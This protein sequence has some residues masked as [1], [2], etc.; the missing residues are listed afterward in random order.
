MD[1]VKP[2]V[3]RKALRVAG[4]YLLFGV[5]WILVSDRI[6]EMFLAGDVESITI[7]Q[8]YKG[9]LF[10]FLTA[11]LIYILT[12]DALKRLLKI[13][14]QLD[15]SEQRYRNLVRN[16]PVGIYHTDRTGELLYVNPYITR[17]FGVS[18]SE[19][20]KRGWSPLLHEDDHD[21]VISKLQK[22]ISRGEIYYEEYRVRLKDCSIR[23]VVD[24]GHPEKNESGELAGYTG[25]LTDVTVRVQIEQR[26]REL[27]EKLKLAV[28]SANIGFWDWDIPG[29]RVFYSREFKQQVGYREDEIGD[30]YSEWQSRL[31]PEDA[32]RV[33]KQLRDCLSNPDKEYH[34][35]FRLR[36]RDG[37]YRWILSRGQLTRD[38]DGNP[39]HFYGSH[40]DVT[41]LKEAELLARENQARLKH[42]LSST[43]TVLYSTILKYDRMVPQWVSDSIT[44]I[45]GYSVEEAM[46]P[47]F[48]EKH[49]H[50]GDRE[51][52][53]QRMELL[54]EK[55][56]LVHEYRFLHKEG[57][58]LYVHDELK[59]LRDE[60]G[61]VHEV[62]GC[63]SDISEQHEQLERIRL[64]ACAFDNTSEGMMVT[65]L[66]TEILFVN[67]ALEE[68]TGY[69]EEELLGNTPQLFRSGRH[70]HLFYEVM[71]DHI[72]K[73][74]RWS[75]E[76]WNRRK[77]GEIYPVWMSI[78]AV[79]DEQQQPSH[80]IGISTDITRLKD[81]ESQLQHLAHYDPLT[82]LPNRLLFQSRVEHAIQHAN[83][84]ENRL[85]IMVVDL[86]DFKKINDSL[87]HPI[88]DE[89]LV[90]VS[91]RW[92]K[93]LRQEDTL[94]RLGG[95]EFV[96]LIEN[97]QKADDAGNI[98]RDLLACLSSPFK[99][100]TGDEVYVEASIGISLFP[101]DGQ[102]A[103]DLLR[104]ADT[105][106][107][108][109]KETG[110]NNFNY[111]TIELGASAVERLELETALRHGIERNEL[112]LHYQPKIHIAN[113]EI[114]GAEALVRWNRPG[115]KLVTPDKFIS[116]AERTGL[117]IPLG[118]W[119]IRQVC[120]QLRDWIDAG[121]EPVRVAVNISVQQFR[122]RQLHE[123][124]SR[125]LARHDIE[126][127]WFE[128]EITES[129][130]MANPDEVIT[131]LTRLREMGIHI[132]LDDF[133]T[134]YSNIAYLTS[135]PIDM[136]KIDASF[137]SNL[138]N[139]PHAVKLINSVIK[140]AKSM[141]LLT[142]AE[143]VETGA[144]LDRLREFECDE[145]QGYYFSK[146]LPEAEFIEL[147]REGRTL[148]SIEN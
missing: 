115:H 86:D 76:V 97:M 35:E 23:H 56:H 21:R 135:F 148:G 37:G 59:I 45:F 1:R 75:G 24:V 71:W 95:D 138:E 146:P 83:R 133:G 136:L 11:V 34:A 92:R 101:D 90:A 121:N 61:K 44:T 5:L 58:T 18:R 4:I 137:V 31:H 119:V 40:V 79:Y 147:L 10:V 62:I 50:P 113:G 22:N 126:P 32:G 41:Y 100:S 15:A 69:S 7:F 140:L 30:D 94:A 142:L 99:L 103:D 70:D 39:D 2:D 26:Q 33:L 122:D 118:E 131:I 102:S 51:Q 89:L 6:L 47:G 145:M 29:K 19:L 67:K 55:D 64:L 13:R 116:L 110:R 57:H 68:M 104:D 9:W 16:V 20:M 38:T 124:I 93:R 109:S 28:S 77:N 36:H 65:D 85:G 73:T 128:I 78:N 3:N 91:G 27:D 43:P 49:L 12:R 63:W 80:Y 53:L 144:Q 134:G 123:F 98:A 25:T 48:W 72:L 120:R 46:H 82:D 54:S 17:L 74:G 139:S 42:L 141:D 107:Y 129:T 66:N 114:C 112:V 88:G 87:G 130:L 14:G 108:R 143:G 111:F 60:T 106:L 81:T 127:Q 96:L 84:H 105:A 125:T 8:T 132:A 117:I 52:C